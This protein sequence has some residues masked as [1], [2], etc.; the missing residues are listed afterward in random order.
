MFSQSVVASAFFYGVE[1]WGGGAKQRDT[2]RLDKLIKKASSVI[3]A[4]Q[5]S[6]ASVAD[7]TTLHKLLSIMDNSSHPLHKLV[8]GRGAASVTGSSQ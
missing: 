6:V 2:R 3:G 5:D 7:R 1:C 4:E 8:L